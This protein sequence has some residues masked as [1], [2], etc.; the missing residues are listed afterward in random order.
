MTKSV[1]IT[2]VFYAS[3]HGRLLRERINSNEFTYQ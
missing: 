1:K 2:K 3:P